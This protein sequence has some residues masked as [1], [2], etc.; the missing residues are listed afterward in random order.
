[1]DPPSGSAPYLFK[2]IGIN[3]V[4]LGAILLYKEGVF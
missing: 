3:T 1:M 4:T 2:G